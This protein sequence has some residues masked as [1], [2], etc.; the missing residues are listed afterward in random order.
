M[1]DHFVI[2]GLGGKKTL[3]GEIRV[4][5]AKNAILKALAAAVLFEDEVP[6]ENVPE[7][8]DVKRMRELLEALKE[9]PILRKD[10]AE[11]MRAS[12]VLTG[13]VLARYKEVHFP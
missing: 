5:G 6:Y 1:A 12:I 2:E 9:G 7:I 10:I 11:R 4:G 8:E 3:K 13:P